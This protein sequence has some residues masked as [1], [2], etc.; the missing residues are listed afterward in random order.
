MA[1]SYNFRSALNGFNR[2]DVVHYI[3][4]INNKNASQ[5][6]QLRTDLASARQET[7]ALKDASDKT[8][9]LEAQIAGLTEQVGQLQDELAA[10]RTAKEAA[11]AALAEMTRQRDEAVS[12]RPAEQR[13]DEAELEAYRRAERMERQAKERADAMCARANGII[14]DATVK[15]DDMARKLNAVAGQ[16]AAQIT[17][18]QESVSDSK[19][20]LQ[21]AAMALYDLQP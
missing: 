4:F 15:V 5:V 2:E 21:N 17:A 9:E 13:S 18:L 6:S 20:V 12:A 16:V 14:S 3:E 7:A 10:L 1:A 11:D 8:A 19:Q